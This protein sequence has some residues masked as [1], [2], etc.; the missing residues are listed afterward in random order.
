MRSFDHIPLAPRRYPFFYGWLIAV[1]GALGFLA[2]TPGQTY[3]VAPFTDP[4]IG[5]LGLTRVQL[6]TAYMIGTIASAFCLTY[7]GRLYDRFGA[8]VMGPAASATLG[9]VL[10]VFSR[11]D[12]IAARLAA[13]FPAVPAST[14]AFAL[15]MLLFFAVR[16]SG[17]GVLTVVSRNMVAKWFDRHRGLVVGVSGMVVAPAFS[18]MPAILN[19]VVQSMG[20]R[21]AWVGMAAVVGGAFTLVALLFYRDNPEDCGLEADGPLARRSLGSRRRPRAAA[22]AYT[23][24]EA[25]R[26]FAFW[27]F[28]IGLGL[29]ALYITAMSFHAGSV[30]ET[31]GL[32]RDRGY[33][34]FLHASIVSLVLRPLVGWLADHAPLKYL[35][36]AMLAGVAVSAVGLCMLGP[37]MSRWIVVAG[38]GLAGSTI[39]TLIT[40]TWPSFYGRTHLGAV[41][42][43]N[44][45]VTV[46]CSALGPWFFS[47][48]KAHTGAYTAAALIVAAVAVVL[49]LLAAAAN[50]P[51]REAASG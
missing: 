2:S 3:G 26:T 17:Q 1:L 19:G 37:G 29:F 4:L 40:V 6:S 28:V 34:I 13:W 48:S 15:V 51:Q 31:A 44:M 23:L 16:L 30:F 46:F 12:G 22:A 11:S 25:Q 9:L 20:W 38:N 47:L 10:L 50:N 5:A 32:S 7:A 27:V 45:S 8:R 49:G 18:A 14:V 41:S 43:F 33:L 35:L 39:G 24:G 21:E 36:M 42:G